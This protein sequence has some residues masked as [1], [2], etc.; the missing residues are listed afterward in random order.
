EQ[1]GSWEGFAKTLSAD[2]SNSDFSVRHLG[3]GS[4]EPP[5]LV[6]TS[7]GSCHIAFDPLN[8]PANPARPE[9]QNI[10]GAIGNQYL[11]ISEILGS[12]CPSDPNE[13]KMFSPARP[14]TS[15]P[16]A[17]PN[18]Q[19]SNPGTINAIINLSQRPVFANEDVIK[20]RPAAACPATPVAGTKCWC[21]ATRD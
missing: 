14:V 17:I 20:W 8:P 19:V 5:F 13:N 2:K 10:K 18:D 12:G 6:G 11:R 1:L 7:C 4:I 9:W 16:S 3:D 21:E 15:A